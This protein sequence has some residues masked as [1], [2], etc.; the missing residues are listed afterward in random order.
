MDIT[1]SITERS[2]RAVEAVEMHA[3]RRSMRISH[4]ERIRNEEI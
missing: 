4:R 2:R 1:W 3:I